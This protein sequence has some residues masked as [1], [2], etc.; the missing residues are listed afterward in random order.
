MDLAGLQ[1]QLGQLGVRPR[2]VRR[3]ALYIDYLD[4]ARTYFTT[5]LAGGGLGGL[6]A[7]YP[8]VAPA[9]GSASLLQE[10]ADILDFYVAPA[11]GSDLRRAY[12]PLPG[13]L[14]HGGAAG[15]TYQDYFTNVILDA[16]AVTF[17]A[18]RP[19]LTPCLV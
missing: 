16:N 6:G 3:A 4:H 14:G 2:D 12:A 11:V 17:G 7:N 9:L 8:F 19:R 5:T 18:N 13:G 10:L 1:T 15:W